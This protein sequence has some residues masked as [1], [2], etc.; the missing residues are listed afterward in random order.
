MLTYKYITVC[1][2]IVEKRLYILTDGLSEFK[3][4]MLAFVLSNEAAKAYWYFTGLF[5]DVFIK[6][7]LLQSFDDWA[8]DVDVVDGALIK[9]GAIFVV[10]FIELHLFSS[11]GKLALPVWSADTTGFV[12]LL[13]LN[14][15]EFKV[16]KLF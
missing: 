16:K 10:T 11:S 4:E 14:D 5:N 6:I 9:G 1:I 2:V 15:S 8:L 3:L 13:F 7:G 12:T